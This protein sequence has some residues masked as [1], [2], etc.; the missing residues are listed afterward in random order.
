MKWLLAGTPPDLTAAAPSYN[1]CCCEG[2]LRDYASRF[3]CLTSSVAAQT[4]CIAKHPE[5]TAFNLLH[6]ACRS[7]VLP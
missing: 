6:A 4:P 5:T 1:G 2:L 3:S 7:G